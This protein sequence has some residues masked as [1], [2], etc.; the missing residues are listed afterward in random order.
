MRRLCLS[1]LEWKIEEALKDAEAPWLAVPPKE[2]ALSPWPS[3]ETLDVAMRFE[4]TRRLPGW[5]R[6]AEGFEALL[7]LFSAERASESAVA[8]SVGVFVQTR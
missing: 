4:S 8:A 7:S 5:R 1:T 3:P 6:W 2:V